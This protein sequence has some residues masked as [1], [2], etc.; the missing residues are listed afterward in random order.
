M[1]Y[2]KRTPKIIPANEIK[3]KIIP[4]TKSVFINLLFT[5]PS[6]SQEGNPNTLA[7]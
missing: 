5:H 1:H 6:P 2:F 7:H 3:D 4:T